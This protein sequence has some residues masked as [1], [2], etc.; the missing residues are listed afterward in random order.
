MN[1][2]VLTMKAKVFVWGRYAA[3]IIVLL[4]VSF[5]AG[6]ALTNPTSSVKAQN[7][8][9]ENAP[10]IPD[11]PNASFACPTITNIA[12]FDNR[13]HVRC[14]VGN[15]GIYYYAYANDASNAIVANQILAVA[16]TAFALGS[17]VWVYYYPS[18]SYNP[19][20]CNTGDCRGLTGISVVP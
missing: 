12:A 20:G 6:Q 10:N 7:N 4:V 14:S 18:S 5:Y 2:E 19:P 11:E 3:L 8:I 9:Q 15:D 17:G 13:I 16:N 1:K